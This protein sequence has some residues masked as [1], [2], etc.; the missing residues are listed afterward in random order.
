M[1]DTPTEQTARAAAERGT[2]G[3]KDADLLQRWAAGDHGDFYALAAEL[4]ET[5]HALHGLAITLRSQVAQYGTGRALYDDTREIDP[6]VRLDF[7]AEMLGL[8][9]SELATA[10]RHAAA[11]HSAISHIGVET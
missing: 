9:A 10:E 6:A 1:P 4:D 8:L 7:A 2:A 3:W 11:F 5:L